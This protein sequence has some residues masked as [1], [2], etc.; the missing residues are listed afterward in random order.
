MFYAG[1]TLSL[2]IMHLDTPRF[3]HSR[4]SKEVGTQRG[5]LMFDGVI[6]TDVKNIG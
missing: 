1:A 3:Q 5:L 2:S 6:E 4:N